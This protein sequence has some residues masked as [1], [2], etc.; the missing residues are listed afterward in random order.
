VELD[1]QRALQ[2]ETLRAALGSA[3]IPV[4][5]LNGTLNTAQKSNSPRADRR[6]QLLVP[7]SAFSQ[8]TRITEPLPWRYSW[9]RRGLMRI[10]PGAY[11]WFDG[12]IELE[13][14]WG[15]PAA[16]L[17]SVALRRLT[18]ELWRTARDT[19]A[20]IYE[21]D[22]SHLLVY[23][24]V[25]SCLGQKGDDRDWTR[26]LAQRALVH[27]PQ[28][29]RTAARRCQVLP[30]LDRALVAAD[31][32][33][34]SRPG[35]GQVFQGWIATPFRLALAF[36]RHVRPRRIGRLLNLTPTLGDFDI[37]CRVVGVETIAERGV[38]VPT[39]DA[40]LI[41]DMA[42]RL[43]ADMPE[44]VV[45]EVGT[46][47][48]AIALALASIRPDASVYATELLP[49]SAS[50]AERNR[51]RLGLRNVRI[52]GGSLLERLPTTLQGRVSLLIANLPFYPK[53]AYAGVGSVPRATIQGSGDDG[54]DLIRRLLGEATDR[55]HPGGW[56]VLQMFAWQWDLM[57][58]ELVEL[59][60]RPATPVKTGPFVIAP[61]QRFSRTFE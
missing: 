52:L 46:G 35:D 26:F 50:C 24:A 55:L 2:V 48:G 10:V 45:V 4:L 27:D 16:P 3:E 34:Q 23:L 39:P 37:R 25:R 41:A 49:R 17:P 8:A 18:A 53:R 14:L 54:L 5:T 61:A 6:V 56:I 58:S 13:L 32:G 57:L 47:S 22:S 21:P 9:T 1:Q 15:V 30:A 43:I 28:A 36:R 20:G 60:F 40:D 31:R 42:G 59:G 51:K 19:G 38:F 11:Y 33:E 7:R 12:G 29:A 44:P